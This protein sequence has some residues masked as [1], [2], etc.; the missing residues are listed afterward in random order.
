VEDLPI[1]ELVT[2]RAIKALTVDALPRA[3]GRDI[4]CLYTDLRQPLLKGVADELGDL[5]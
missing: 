1:Q 3:I 2:H 4:K 5:M